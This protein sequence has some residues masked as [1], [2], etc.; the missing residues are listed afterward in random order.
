MHCNEIETRLDAY[1]DGEMPA[2]E[3][4][5]LEIHLNECSACRRELKARRK[6]R[7]LFSGQPRVTAPP[8]LLERIVA[9]AGEEGDRT[10]HLAGSPDLRW[11]RRARWPLV[12]VGAASLVFVLVLLVLP[13]LRE[14]EGGGVLTVPFTT[15]AR[16]VVPRYGEKAG[17]R[18]PVKFGGIDVGETLQRRLK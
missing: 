14:R 2:E 16:V 4:T 1:I 6:L 11:W 8:G 7:R 13:K 5:A 17:Q 18:A 3:I 9:A 15:P 10:E 12:F